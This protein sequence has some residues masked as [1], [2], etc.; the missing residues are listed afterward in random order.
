MTKTKRNFIKKKKVVEYREKLIG[1]KKQIDAEIILR[2]FEY[3]PTGKTGIYGQG[4]AMTDT[5]DDRTQTHLE[6]YKFTRYKN[7]KD[8]IDL[9]NLTCNHPYHWTTMRVL[10]S[11]KSSKTAK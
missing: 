3:K 8:E 10:D 11:S 9:V 5:N 7:G 2:T 1:Y 6:G 4:V